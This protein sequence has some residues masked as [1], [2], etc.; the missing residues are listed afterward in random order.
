MDFVTHILW[1]LFLAGTPLA[2]YGFGS[3]LGQL[4][5]QRPWVKGQAA[6]FG[7]GLLLFVVLYLNVRRHYH[8]TCVC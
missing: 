7:L 3:A 8:H 4:I 6:A 1:F 5:W 2:L